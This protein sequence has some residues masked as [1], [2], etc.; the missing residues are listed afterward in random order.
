MKK[1]KDIINNNK[2]KIW[3]FVL[4]NLK[5]YPLLKNNSKTEMINPKINNINSI[6]PNTANGLPLN[7]AEIVGY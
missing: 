6:F 7:V 5:L 3:D 4:F 2:E 1:A